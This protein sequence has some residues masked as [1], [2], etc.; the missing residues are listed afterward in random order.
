MKTKS[1]K[2]Y[3]SI[4]R[5]VIAIASV[6]VI[7]LTGTYSAFAADGGQQT[8]IFVENCNL[9][10]EY[11]LL[12][13]QELNTYLPHDTDPMQTA[14]GNV[15]SILNVYRKQLID[16]QSIPEAK[17]RLL[18]KEATL[19][20]T[21]GVAAAKLTWIYYYNLRSLDS[22]ESITRVQKAYNG[23]LEEIDRASESTVL[24]PSAELM[25]AALNNTIYEEKIASLAKKGDSIASSSIIAGGIDKIGE[26]ESS[27]ILASQ[28]VAVYNRTLQE[29][30]LQRSKD[31]L[32][33]ELE[34]I[35]GI[36]RP[37]QI[38]SENG[39]VALFNYRLLNASTIGEMNMALQSALEKLLETS[40]AQIYRYLFTST[41]RENI[42]IEVSG[43]TESN[44]AADV[45][46][47]FSS[48]TLEW[49]KACAK[50]EISTTIY[51]GGAVGDAELKRLEE[52]FNAAGGIIDSCQS[53]ADINT[54]KIRA[55]FLKLCY[56]ELC[57]VNSE[58]EV[59]LKPY[60]PPRFT[61]QSKNAYTSAI[62][63]IF[64][65][66]GSTQFESSCNTTLV[67]LQA[68]LKNILNESK[69]ERFLLDHKKIIAKP[70][71][72]LTTLDE[73]ALKQAIS[74]YTKLEKEVSL[75]L[76][77]QINSIVEKYNIVLSQIIRARSTNDA[78]YLDI[79]EI[80][81]TELKNIPRN[82]IADYYNKCDL[83][84]KK[85]DV[86]YQT[87]ATYREIASG[88]LYESYS[89]S[90][91]ESLIRI[92]RENATHLSALDLDD[93]ALLEEDMNELGDF[94]K[95]ALYRKN[96]TVRIRVATRNSES[97]QIKAIVADANTRINA[98]FNKAEMLSIADKA[99][100]K[101]N[102]HLTADSIDIKAER[103]KATIDAMKFLNADQKSNFKSQI[104]ALQS[105]SR[106]N[107]LRAENLT[108][109]E[110]IWNTFSES[111]ELTLESAESQD[112]ISSRDAH[113]NLFKKE[114]DELSGH[115][116][117]M[118]YLTSKESDDFSNKLQNLQVAFKTERVSVQTS[119]EVEQL[120]VKAIETLGYLSNS[121]FEI[122]LSNRKAELTA[123]IEEYKNTESKYS[124]E[125]Y[126]KVL[127]IISSFKSELVSA[128]N[129]SA[130]DELFKSSLEKIEAVSDLLRDAKQNALSTLESRVRSYKK[131]S[132]LY[133]SSALDSIEKIF[134]EAKREIEAYSSISDVEGVAA[135][136]NKYML[137]LAAIN[138]DYASSSPDGL[139]FL[140][141]GAAYPLQYDFVN[142]YW[143]LI[144]LPDSLPSESTLAIIP[145]SGSDMDD[146]SRI[147]RSAARSK[148]IKFYTNSLSSRQLKE[149]KRSVVALAV[150]VSLSSSAQ[151]NSP[152]TLQMLLPEDCRDQSILGVAFIAEDGSVEFYSAEQRDALIS[153]T[154]NHLSKYYI[155]AERTTDLGWL[156]ILISAIIAIEFLI[157]AF[158]LL[159]RVKRKRKED[160]MFPLISSSF[161]GPLYASVLTKIRPEGALTTTVLL[162]V[163]ALAL[164]CAIALLARA[165]LSYLKGNQ[166]YI[167]RGGQ[168]SDAPQRKK[169]LL[170][171]NARREL[172]RAKTYALNEAQAQK[173]SSATAENIYCPTEPDN[174]EAL[175]E[176]EILC[177]VAARERE[178]TFADGDIEQICESEGGDDSDS[179][180][181]QPR[182]RA[183]INLDVIAQK[184]SDGDLVTLEALKRKHLVP[185]K[186]DH[187]K[188]LARGALSKSLVIEAHDFSR[189][190]EEMLGAVGGE[191]IR[192]KKA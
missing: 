123:R 73:L 107:S 175:Q 34:D 138:R 43:A 158:L 35:F 51:S 98:S 6:C 46:S 93:A 30:H 190:A 58:I 157:F 72:E 79:C 125:N 139:G 165:E 81:C 121:S 95:L 84:L 31:F 146:A 60:D 189:A 187:L 4:F 71:G 116:R 2:G 86:L 23:Y 52:K 154:L 13:S 45:L 170:P 42:S 39:A 88:K 167:S 172:L 33:S 68:E 132:T 74:D 144:Y 75:S 19:I 159:L 184:F 67:G 113:L 8:D 55:R 9:T 127:E 110:F 186:T 99:I 7:L 62:D 153:L 161:T 108:V 124:A 89:A 162:S 48:Y 94:A 90:E 3:R 174:T 143:G 27:D 38:F 14:S 155:I 49:A 179:E 11:S 56:T 178:S 5:I 54:E 83:V 25:A 69:A 133:S 78:L 181:R 168:E 148:S 192:I 130:C 21:K 50:D 142:G 17:T 166:R 103:Q 101:I 53:I 134:D 141:E 22:T 15:L 29:L 47:L 188:V 114:C 20:Y 104:Q 77:S 126:N 106:E 24:E 147:I 1:I 177:A 173:E 117:S 57:S 150:D 70:S 180:Y 185:K 41:L 87:V 109:L 164:G 128:T 37:D 40:E 183:E 119:L 149:I 102:R 18:G 129:V 163:G 135:S 91:R 122:N 96:E 59:V 176:S 145:L 85:A 137:K 92:C 171:K 36:I 156:I 97:A 61:A 140:A 151:L 112:L 120:Y 28:H 105:D 118:L 131:L 12:L 80:F 66:T 16:L 115:L 82:N 63:A 182:H 44:L 152:F 100:F 10:E 191:A 136:L 169:A 76:T 64:S 111:L 65:M 160:N 26:L 32:Y